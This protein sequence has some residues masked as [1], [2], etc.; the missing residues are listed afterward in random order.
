VIFKHRIAMQR[1]H[2]H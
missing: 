1:S 2:K